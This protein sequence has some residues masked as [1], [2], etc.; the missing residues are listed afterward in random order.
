MHGEKGN[1]LEVAKICEK[2]II[3]ATV[4][5]EEDEAPSIDQNLANL[6]A[7]SPTGP[8]LERSKS[9]EIPDVPENVLAE[10]QRSVELEEKPKQNLVLELRKVLLEKDN[11]EAVNISSSCA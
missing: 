1:V 2:A 5:F 7:T 10:P 4:S 9:L 8:I 11:L 3:S 6:S